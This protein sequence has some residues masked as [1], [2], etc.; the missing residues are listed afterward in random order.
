MRNCPLPAAYIA[1]LA[2]AL[3]LCQ[4]SSRADCCSFSRYN[5]R[6][7]A[8]IWCADGRVL[9]WTKPGIDVHEQQ[10]MWREH[11][12]RP[13]FNWQAADGGWS[14]HELEFRPL[15]LVSF[16][17]HVLLGS[18]RPVR[19]EVET[20]VDELNED[21]RIE[22]AAPDAL[23][24]E[25]CSEGEVASTPVASS[26]GVSFVDEAQRALSGGLAA[27]ASLPAEARQ[28]AQPLPDFE[29]YRLCPPDG[30]AVAWDSTLAGSPEFAASCSGVYGTGQAAS[31]QAY[32]AAGSP[33]L[34]PTTIC[35]A[36]TGV[37]LNHPD[38][39][40]RLADKAVDCNYRN[41]V[42]STA[43]NRPG[44]DQ[45]LVRREAEALAGFPRQAVKARPA[46]HGTCVAGIVARCTAGYKS[47]D[48]RD[49]VRILPISVKSE[50]VYAVTGWK[51]KSPISA[52]I[53]VIA[54]LNQEFPVNKQDL[55]NEPDGQ[56]RVV[57]LSAGIPRTYF[58][59]R[60]W[61]IVEP[62]VS[63]AEEAIREDLKA[64]DR[65]Y[66]FAAGNERQAQPNRPGT[67]D[68]VV[69]V[70]A[71]MP[72]GPQPWD[73]PA[74]N[75]GSNLGEKCVSAPGYGIITSTLF[76]SPNL[77]YLPENEIP[78]ARPNFS[79]PPRPEPWT[80]QTNRF[81]ATSAATPQVSALAALLYATS[82]DLTFR[83]V[84]DRILQS[85]GG[86]E[87]TADRGKSRG[88]VDY[89][90]ALSW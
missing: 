31:L 71:T 46:S 3:A 79:T 12:L 6:N 40:D 70:S 34:T 5:A 41:Y 67:L 69:S 11:G 10:Q 76:P 27:W 65:V 80:M 14:Y 8:N 53:K 48:G 77:A 73:S 64:N 18:L 49:A 54:C 21:P 78:Q 59:G 85:T 84:E 43:N 55:T 9:A 24:V 38:L 72:Y 7:A 89:R 29:Y 87:L 2:L 90:S 32:R 26:Y 23:I 75:E 33:P 42:V 35:V 50:R 15:D 57:S 37:F 88:L 39:R 19:R 17:Q 28:L 16:C 36:D 47:A 66:V 58:S 63:K 81:S 13:R 45:R 61:R 74:S 22:L 86:R 56:V 82:Q 68:E 20:V 30:E 51:V 4:T 83:L 1:L 25:W 52:F 62:I 44:S 60:E